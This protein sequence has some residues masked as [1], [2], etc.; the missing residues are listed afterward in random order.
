VIATE[1]EVALFENTDDGWKFIMVWIDY[2]DLAAFDGDYS[3]DE[4]HAA[5][6]QHPF[7]QERSLPVVI[8][9]EDENGEPRLFG[10][11]EYVDK[12]ADDFDW[13]SIHWGFTLTLEWEVEDEGEDE[14]EEDDDGE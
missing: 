2:D 10:A 12:I 9:F 7:V 3:E 6:E 4:W 11:E 1:H 13:D 8:A 5:I 14:E